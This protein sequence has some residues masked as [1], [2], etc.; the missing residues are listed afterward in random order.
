MTNS[1]IG[2]T[3]PFF[4]RIGQFL[5]IP[6]GCESL[7]IPAYLGGYPAGAKCIAEA[8]RQKQ[9]TKRSAGRLLL[10]SNNCG[11]AFLFG[12]LG[13]A[14][15]HTWML[16]AMWGIQIFGSVLIARILP[17]LSESACIPL[18]EKFSLPECLQSSISIMS[19]ICGWVILFRILIAFLQRWLLCRLP[20]ETQI[21]LMGLLELSNGCCCL[22]AV[23]DLRLRFL[24]CSVMLS[25]GGICVTMQTASAATPL[26]ILPYL[27]FKAVQSL[28]TVCI[29]SAFVY[30]LPLLLPF[31]AV[32]FLI[33]KKVLAKRNTIMYNGS[34]TQR[35]N[36]YAVS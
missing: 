15:P 5:G 35:R 3:F 17:A 24:L 21:F 18:N 23:A 31:A 8:Y 27:L 14:F 22:S 20:M 29:V 7:L 34:I 11:P 9:I 32:L 16:W 4:R 6:E 12:I 1:F 19:S 33:L 25:F 2:I 13:N 36:Q 28:F 26:P 30:H 10:F